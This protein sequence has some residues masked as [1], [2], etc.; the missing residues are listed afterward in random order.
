MMDPPRPEALLEGL[1]RIQDKINSHRIAKRT[2]V[3]V[4]GFGRV[5]DKIEDDLPVPHHTG[6]VDAPAGRDPLTEHQKIT[7]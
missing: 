3:E 5:G 7:G 1:M 2:S 4:T 6:Y